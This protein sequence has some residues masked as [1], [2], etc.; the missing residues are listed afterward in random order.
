ML[1]V[2]EPDD[3]DTFRSMLIDA[4]TRRAT[5]ITIYRVQVRDL[6]ESYI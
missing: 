5:K 1:P 4:D 3:I 6:L 2:V